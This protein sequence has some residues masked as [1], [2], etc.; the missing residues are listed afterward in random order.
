MGLD[1][2]HK[3]FSGSYSSFNSWRKIIAWEMGIDLVQM[4]GFGGDKSWTPFENLDLY[5]LLN[6]E[7][8]D[9]ILTPS[10]CS[11]IIRGL[12]K[13]NFPDQET[14]EIALQFIEGCK[15]AISKNENLEFK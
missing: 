5:P 14:S 13:V 10:E 1:I 7:D 15:L 8:C 9:G 2:T 6:H 11:K 4:E 3:T 12:A